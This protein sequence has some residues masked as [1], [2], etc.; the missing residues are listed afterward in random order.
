VRL[1]SG[2]GDRGTL[3]PACA[4]RTALHGEVGRYPWRFADGSPIRIIGDSAWWRVLM[5]KQ[6]VLKRL[7]ILVGRYYSHP[8]EQAEFRNPSEGEEAKLKALGIGT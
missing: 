4:W 8:E 7:P 5:A 1:G 6:K 3:G 2:T